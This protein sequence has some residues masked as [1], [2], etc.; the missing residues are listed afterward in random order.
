[1][2]FWLV[3]T[4]NSSMSIVS[5]A[6]RVDLI[7]IASEWVNELVKVMSRE[8]EGLSQLGSLVFPWDFAWLLAGLAKSSNLDFQS[9]LTRCLCYSSSNRAYWS[10]T[11]LNRLIFTRNASSWIGLMHKTCLDMKFWFWHFWILGVEPQNFE[12]FSEFGLETH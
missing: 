12:H 6:N 7:T 5:T 2:D 9:Q 1:M 4:H 8:Q 11:M 10:S 3:L